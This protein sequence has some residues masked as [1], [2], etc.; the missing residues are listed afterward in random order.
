MGIMLICFLGYATPN[1]LAEYGINLV[2]S[3]IQSPHFTVESICVVK[4]LSM[5]TKKSLPTE[6]SSSDNTPKIAE[7]MR[8]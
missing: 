1:I 5:R 4:K 2:L 7:V 8:T 6:M 3:E